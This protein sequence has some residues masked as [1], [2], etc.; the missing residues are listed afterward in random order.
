MGNGSGTTPRDTHTYTH[1]RHRF[2]DSVWRWEGRL[3]YTM[4]GDYGYTWETKGWDL[5]WDG[6]G[7][8]Q[9]PGNLDGMD[10]SWMV[11]PVEKSGEPCTPSFRRGDVRER[12]G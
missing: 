12:G 3:D 10:G 9:Q 2:L 1:T 8:G 11:V 7:M 5:A 4:G 6:T